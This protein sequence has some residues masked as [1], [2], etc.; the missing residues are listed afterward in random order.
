[1]RKYNSDW[2]AS[3]PI[4]KR[5][6]GLLS[7]QTAGESQWLQ[8]E[9]LHY[10][11]DQITELL[12]DILI[13]CEA[14]ELTLLVTRSADSNALACK[15]AGAR[16]IIVHIGLLEQLWSLIVR[17]AHAPT[18]RAIAYPFTL[19]D[20]SEGE[21]P[22]LDFVNWSLPNE[23]TEFF[24]YVHLLMLEYIVLH[25]IA[26]HERGHLTLG[27]HNSKI[28][29]HDERLERTKACAMVRS[30]EAFS[31]RDLE[32][33]ADVYAIDLALLSLDAQFPFESDQWDQGE[34]SGHLYQSLFAHLLVAQQLDEQSP[35]ETFPSPTH[36]HPAPV[37]RALNYTNLLTHG[38]HQIAGG[39]FDAYREAHDQAWT[40]ASYVA[41]LEGGSE[42]I[43]HGE[44][45]AEG[46]LERFHVDEKLCH[47]AVSRLD[48]KMGLPRMG[49]S[50]E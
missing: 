48:A 50:R 39:S 5:F 24:L 49:L 26:H 46:L 14:S 4:V 9:R 35:P 21:G 11:F 34:A 25:E 12:D 19:P 32:F 18:V 29:L 7:E 1:M 31:S 40:E 33:D 42:G 43:W 6:G 47:E 27:V 8:R 15:D 22:S 23:R 30:D 28:S 3:K 44:N 13:G 36:L 38:F 45:I 17:I 37:Y 10:V 41:E 20:R 16:A 2:W